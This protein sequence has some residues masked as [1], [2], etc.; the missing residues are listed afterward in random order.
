MKKLFIYAAVFMFCFLSGAAGAAVNQVRLNNGMLLLLEENHSLPIVSMQLWVKT[1]SVNEDDSTNGLSHFIEHMIFKGTQE[2]A[3]ERV[4]EEVEKRGGVI[5]AATS[6]DFTYFYITLPVNLNEYLGETFAPN[7]VETGLDILFQ[8]SSMATFPQDELENERFVVL[9][10]ISRKEDAP[11]R[12]L[13]EA[14]SKM[15]FRGHPYVR[16]VLGTEENISGFKREDLIAYYEKHYIPSNFVLVVTGDFNSRRVTSQ[17]KKIFTGQFNKYVLKAVPAAQVPDTAPG[18]E[19]ITIEEDVQHAYVVMGVP[20]P[21]GNSY[22]AYVMDVLAHVMG[23]GRSSRLY[24]SLRE[25]KRL[26]WDI[27]SSFSTQV[28]N[29]PFY[30]SFEC[31]P[32]KIAAVKE[33]VFKEIKRMSQ[34]LCTRDEIDRA[35]AGLES[36]HLMS[37]ETCS[38]RG[39]IMG[40]YEIIGS[41]R[42]G[43]DYVDRMR[44]VSPEDIKRVASKYLNADLFKCAMVV[45]EGKN[46]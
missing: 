44:K 7:S 6:K 31:E 42:L 12:V 25:Q 30:V 41:Y 46:K 33:E 35:K 38:G 4:F 18:Q 37:T 14:F 16:T 45:P 11:Q 39:F 8:F 5:N 13:W 2:Y 28:Y 34:E 40:Y 36:G 15:L 1:G 21:M 3:V 43:L 19:E 32:D 23:S 9:E 24:Q 27:G 22:D 29:G 17:V 10:E 26:V 20:G